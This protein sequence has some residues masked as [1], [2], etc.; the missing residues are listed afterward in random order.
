MA[1]FEQ[2]EVLHQEMLRSVTDVKDYFSS[3]EYHS[4]RR[5]AGFAFTRL[6]PQME[7]FLDVVRGVRDGARIG[8]PGI[9]RALC[10]PGRFLRS[11]STANLPAA[12]KIT[13]DEIIDNVFFLGLLCHFSLHTFPT[14]GDVHRVA[15]E[16]LFEAWLPE[17]LIADRT[18]KTYSTSANRLPDRLFESYFVKHI[19]PTLKTQFKL[20]FWSLSK[21]HSFFRNLFF[22]GA[23]LGMHF[24]MMTRDNR[25]E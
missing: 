2:V 15:L 6:V 23:R 1:I 3:E 17:S 19:K 8:H 12:L 20:G 25:S 5:T 14:R 4:L 24:D 18:M 13:M 10:F 11:Q 7:V 22:A 9:E 21:S 16:R